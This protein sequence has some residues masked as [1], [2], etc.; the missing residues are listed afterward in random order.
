M[1]TYITGEKAKPF[2]T[3]ESWTE[4]DHKT[5]FSARVNDAL[6]AG[7]K[8]HGPPAY[9]WVPAPDGKGGAV[10]GVQSMIREQ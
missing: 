7:Y 4:A 5:R 2:I 3:I 10:L 1:K 9:F 8:F 6:A